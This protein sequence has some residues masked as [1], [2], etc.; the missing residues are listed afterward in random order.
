MLVAF[1][2]GGVFT[3]WN[4][5][6]LHEFGVVKKGAIYRSSSPTVGQLERLIHRYGIKTVVSLRWKPDAYNPHVMNEFGLKY[7]KI[8]MQSSEPISQKTIKLFFEIVD[9]PKNWPVLVHCGGGEERTGLM[10]ALYRRWRNG[11]TPEQA[12]DE[13]REYDFDKSD[14]KTALAASVL[15]LL[16]KTNPPGSLNDSAA[17]EGEAAVD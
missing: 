12:I 2:V 15:K 6:R 16:C 17:S 4:V 13:M 1:L 5:Y 8:P 10:V 14:E 11:W 3:V 7:V 9:N